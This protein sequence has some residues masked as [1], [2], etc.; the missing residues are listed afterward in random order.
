MRAGHHEEDEFV[1][2]K[3]ITQRD[4]SSIWDRNSKGL[5]ACSHAQWKLPF[6]G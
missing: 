1:V 3:N 6:I 2:E 4:F 5:W